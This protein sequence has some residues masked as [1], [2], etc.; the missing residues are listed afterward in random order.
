MDGQERDHDSDGLVLY[1]SLVNRKLPFIPVAGPGSKMITWY[2]C[3]VTPYDSSHLYVLISS[4]TVVAVLPAIK[5]PA[6]DPYFLFRLKVSCEV[7][8]NPGAGGTQG[9]TSLST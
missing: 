5:P 9:P 1:N 7:L 2:A 4:L 3:G 8:L 6:L